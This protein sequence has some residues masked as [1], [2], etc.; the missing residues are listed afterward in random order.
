[1]NQNPGN[2]ADHVLVNVCNVDAAAI[3]RGAPV[4]L[5]VNATADGLNV[6][7]PSTAGAAKSNALLY[8]ISTDT[9]PVNG[10]NDAVAFGY[11]P[12][13]LIGKLTRANSTTTWAS[14]A[15]IASFAALT[16]DTVNNCFVTL[17]ASAVGSSF[18]PYA[19]LIDSIASIAS[20]A[21]ATTDT[22][23]V[24][25]TGYRAFLRIL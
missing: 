9:I 20:S 21:T 1:M 8:G 18:L 16:I 3:P 22:R 25:T 14:Q 6:V 23:T 12:Y 10:F 4:I 11:C 15:S 7:L 13:L 24:L 2:K 19:V 5:N 17:A